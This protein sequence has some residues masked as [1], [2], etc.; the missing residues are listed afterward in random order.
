MTI[1]TIFGLFQGNKNK[2]VAFY[3]QYI[4]QLDH[5]QT[6]VNIYLI[7]SKDDRA[8]CIEK[9]NILYR[10]AAEYQKEQ[11]K[12]LIDSKSILKQINISCNK[13][14]DIFYNS[15]I[16]DTIINADA[17]LFYLIG[18]GGEYN[19]ILEHNKLVRSQR[20]SE[21]ETRLLLR[22]Q[23]EKAEKARISK[24]TRE[25]ILKNRRVYP[26]NLVTFK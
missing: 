10:I 3:D 14:L 17:N 16:N 23:Q 26:D 6:M 25:R 21:K 12:T 5:E 1:K 19:K 24:D 7:L 15:Y 9:D 13:V 11:L 20:E 22:E 4:E 2:Q 8:F 18:K